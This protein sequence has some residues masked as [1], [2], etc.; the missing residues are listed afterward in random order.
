MINIDRRIQLAHV[1]FIVVAPL[2]GAVVATARIPLY[3]VHTVALV[4]SFIL[5]VLT[6]LAIEVGFHR[7]ISHQAF[8]ANRWLW[9]AFVVLGAM[10]AQGPGIYWAALHRTHHAHSDT[11]R[12]P[13]SPNT[14]EG[15]RGLFRGHIGWMFEPVPLEI[16]DTLTDMAKMRWLLKF[17]R[18]Y[19]L[20]MVLGLLLPALF[21]G[22]VTHSRSGAIDGF[23][24]AGLVRIFVLQHAI[25]SINSLC[26]RRGDRPFESGDRSVDVRWLALPT[27]GGSLHNT[28]HAFPSTARNDVVP[29]TFDPGWWLLV[30]LSKVGLVTETNSPSERAVT[31]R[32]RDAKAG[33]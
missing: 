16:F 10:A 19:Y 1:W 14:D 22:L 6:T 32:S 2:A 29:G 7:G 3:G 31:R 30:V 24:W 33:G 21:C 12:D 23:L 26:H 4:T 28:H 27:M 9:A 25:W 8:K 5:F 11:E 18:L 20:W 17:D 15:L 13:H